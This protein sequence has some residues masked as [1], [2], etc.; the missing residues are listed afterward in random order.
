MNINQRRAHAARC[1]STMNFALPAADLVRSSIDLLPDNESHALAWKASDDGV[2]NAI[3]LMY[4]HKH[5][6]P[7]DRWFAL[8]FQALQAVISNC[9]R[10]TFE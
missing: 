9:L 7:G 6:D 3:W 4:S 10:Y 1:I 2:T 8:V 5:W